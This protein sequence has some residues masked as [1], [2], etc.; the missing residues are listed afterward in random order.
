MK[1]FSPSLNLIPKKMWG[2]NWLKEREKR[3]DINI[4]CECEREKAREELEKLQ[5]I[6]GLEITIATTKIK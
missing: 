1:A 3:K 5:E 2:R 4:V 6:R